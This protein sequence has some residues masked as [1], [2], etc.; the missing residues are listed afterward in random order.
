MLDWSTYDVVV[1]KRVGMLLHFVHVHHYLLHLVCTVKP[2]HK[3]V[4]PR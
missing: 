2:V 1:L 3:R 4:W